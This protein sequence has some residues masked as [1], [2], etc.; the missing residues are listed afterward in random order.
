MTVFRLDIDDWDVNA[1]VRNVEWPWSVFARNYREGFGNDTFQFDVFDLND[2]DA[3]AD[4]LPD[5]VMPY[6]GTIA[7]SSKRQ[8][9]V[10]WLVDQGC[11]VATVSSDQGCD[12][13]L[14]H[15]P[16]ALDVFDASRSKYHR[17]RDNGTIMSVRYWVISERNVPI[18]SH[19]F[20]IQLE[21]R[22]SVDLF[23]SSDFKESCES[24]GMHGLKFFP[25]VGA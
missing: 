12:F 24:E 2:R 4:R 23:C 19:L 16:I 14:V 11:H 15:S 21:S 9:F 18:D 20:H 3:S 17:F 10:R 25:I 22:T 6:P 1:V 8:K 5:I 7:V 13:Q